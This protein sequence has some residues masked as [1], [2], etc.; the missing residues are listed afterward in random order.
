M[1]YSIQTIHVMATVTSTTKYDHLRVRD[2]VFVSTSVG[3][4][5]E[6]ILMSTSCQD[7]GKRPTQ[8]DHQQAIIFEVVDK[9]IGRRYI[10]NF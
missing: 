6:S 7:V 2:N 4:G 3:N 1:T 10:L 8:N 9:L 5:S